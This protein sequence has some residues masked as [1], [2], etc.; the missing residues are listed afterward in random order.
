MT[1][2]DTKIHNILFTY[3]REVSGAIVGTE[4]VK[5]KASGVPHLVAKVAV[6]FNALH[7]K[8]DIAS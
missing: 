7:I 1:L 6:A 8:V 5:G 4:L 2:K 3:A